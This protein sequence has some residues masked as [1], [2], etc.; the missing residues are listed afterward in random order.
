MGG[1]VSNPS[2]R[3]KLKTRVHSQDFIRF[4]RGSCIFCFIAPIERLT[5]AGSMQQVDVCE[6]VTVDYESSVGSTIHHYQNYH[7]VDATEICP[8]LVVA[9]GSALDHQSQ[10]EST[11]RFDDTLNNI[12]ISC[13]D[14]NFTKRSNVVE[15]PSLASQRKKLSVVTLA[16]S[17]IARHLELPFVEPHE[18][19]PC[20]SSSIYSCP[21]YPTSVFMGTTTGEGMSLVL[22]SK[23]SEN[24]EKSFST[25]SRQY[26]E[27]C[28]GRNETVKSYISRKGFDAFRERLKHGILDLGLAIQAQKQGAARKEFYAVFN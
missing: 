9:A 2:K 5:G 24:F 21:C 27:I 18:K 4:F 23:V 13:V 19:V 20:C 6:F 26:K 11:P 22:Y 3:L 14:G 17:H 15:D 25:I 8:S 16:I 28:N 10:T 12:D 7:Q 1:C